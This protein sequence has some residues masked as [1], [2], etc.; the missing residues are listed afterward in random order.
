MWHRCHRR[1]RT[2]S[3]NRAR[4]PDAMHR[5]DDV[6]AHDDVVR[7]WRAGA[8]P[9]ER[10]HEALAVTGAAFSPQ[11][12]RTFLERTLLSFAVGALA[13]A[14]GFFIAANWQALGRF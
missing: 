6:S 10:V 4:W 8:I 11:A 7:W 2:A 9:R 14:L 12:W 5:I 3:A 1:L 13:A